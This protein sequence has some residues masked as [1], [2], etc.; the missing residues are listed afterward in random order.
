MVTIRRMAGATAVQLA[1]AHLARRLLA[2]GAAVWLV[3]F[4]VL[5]AR[6]EARVAHV[7]DVQT[8]A[9]LHAGPSACHDHNPVSHVHGS[10]AAG[11]HDA[12][13]LLTVLHQGAAPAVAWTGICVV[14]FTPSDRAP[15][16]F[17]PVVRSR[18]VYRVAPKTSPPARV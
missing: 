18:G 15:R 1:S 9:I 17:E 5:G 10:P 16:A 11:D 12:C 8:G 13:E 7:I 4:G 2:V 6:H 14:V 3:V